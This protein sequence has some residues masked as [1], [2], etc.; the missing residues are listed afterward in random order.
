[1]A[2]G[3]KRTQRISDLI[4]TSLAEILHKDAKD[5]RFGIITITSVDVAHDLSFAKVYVSVLEEDKSKE[6]IAALNNAA[7][8]LRYNLAQ[9][10]ELRTTPELK[11]IYDD[12]TVRGH[13]IESLINSVIKKQ[14]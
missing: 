3:F 6:T 12:S 8:F 9:A 4:Q 5:M 7:K 13:R 14:D 10:V 2:K 11:F 1:M